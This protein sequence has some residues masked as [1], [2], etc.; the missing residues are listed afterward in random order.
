MVD[1]VIATNL[2]QGLVLRNYKMVEKEEASPLGPRTIRKAQ[3]V[4][5]SLVLPGN[6]AHLRDLNPAAPVRY[7]YRISY[8]TG[9]DGDAA[10]QWINSQIEADKFH[11][12]DEGSLLGSHAVIW[13]STKEEVEAKARSL[14]KKDQARSGLEPMDPSD[15]PREFRGQRLKLETAEDQKNKPQLQE[16]IAF[17]DSE[18]GERG[19]ADDGKQT[20]VSRKRS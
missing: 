4:G 20:R 14:T 18:S 13:G 9:Q 8:F 6:G 10:Q 1:I 15:L 17:V 7:G 5:K 12:E 16:P 2:P 11:E 3:Q 19:Y